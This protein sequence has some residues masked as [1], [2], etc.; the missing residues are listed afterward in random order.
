MNRPAD[1]YLGLREQALGVRAEHL[2][3][4]PRGRILAL[5]MEMGYPEAVATLVGLADGTTSMYFSTG[6]GIIGGGAHE[7]VDA[8][9]RRWLDL[10]EDF[11][12]SFAPALQAPALPEDGET[13][14]VAIA[15]DGRFA[16]SAPEQELGVGRHPASPLFHAGHDVITELRLIDEAGSRES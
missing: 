3:E 11:V 16:L 5:L 9:T 15:T 14:F 4:P 1:D 2:A 12:D 6:G 8:A 7:L 13:Q 10:A